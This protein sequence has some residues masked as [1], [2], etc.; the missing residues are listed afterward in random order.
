MPM[1]IEILKNETA[2]RLN[3]NERGGLENW[4]QIFCPSKYTI[5]AIE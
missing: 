5:E 2:Y 4:F 3:L 1:T